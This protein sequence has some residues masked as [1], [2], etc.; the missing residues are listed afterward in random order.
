MNKVIIMGRLGQDP[1]LKYLPNG[2][3]VANFSVATTKKWK[4]NEGAPQEKT[5]W[6]KIVIWG[7]LAE[8]AN[9]YLSK[10]R[11]VLLQGELQTRSWDD[12]D[13]VKRYTTEIVASELEFIGSGEKKDQAGGSGSNDPGPG[14]NFASDDIPL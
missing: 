3:A 8:L 2:T 9:Q 12:R 11:Q 1:E 6:H 4:N 13:G 10:G 14:S 7:K 5:E